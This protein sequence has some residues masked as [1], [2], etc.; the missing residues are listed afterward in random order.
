[1]ATDREVGVVEAH[2]GLPASGVR[3]HLL[4][5]IAE[6]VT[7]SLHQLEVGN[8]RARPCDVT[9]IG[10][11]DSPF[12]SEQ[13]DTVRPCEPAQIPD[14]DEVRD[15]QEVEPALLRELRSTRRPLLEEAH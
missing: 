1:M 11:E 4:G 15:E 9:E 2:A 7:L 14:V 8:L 10:D 13:T 12:A 5:D 6:Q 3:L